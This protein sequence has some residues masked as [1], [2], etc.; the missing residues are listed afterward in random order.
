M[1]HNSARLSDKLLMR[2]LMRALRDMPG[3]KRSYA[4]LK[5]R[6]WANSTPKTMRAIEERR[7]E[8]I[9]HRA[10]GTTPPGPGTASHDRVTTATVDEKTR[11]EIDRT[12]RMN[13]RDGKRRG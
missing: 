12:R 9:K 3:V 1:E 6:G 13:T 8:T 7:A 4:E 10:A 11:A 2:V 5:R